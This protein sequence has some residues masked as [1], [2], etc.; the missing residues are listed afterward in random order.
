MA[1]DP[2]RTRKPHVK[3]ELDWEENRVQRWVK[4]NPSILRIIAVQ[5]LC[6]YDLVRQIAYGKWVCDPKHDVLKAL[7][8]AGWPGISPHLPEKRKRKKDAAN[9]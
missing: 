8:V 2:N 1:Y 3:R 4:A 7:I 5:H 6:T 9:E